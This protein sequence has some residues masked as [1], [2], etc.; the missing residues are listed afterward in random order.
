MNYDELR[1]FY[2]Y[3][4]ACLIAGYCDEDMVDCLPQAE[5]CLS[6][7]NDELKAKFDDDTEHGGIFT[8]HIIIMLQNWHTACNLL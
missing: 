3:G 1:H 5:K 8:R 7:T 4:I 6:L 2:I